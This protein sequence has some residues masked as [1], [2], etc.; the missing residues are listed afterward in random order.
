MVT[1]A[2]LSNPQRA[3]LVDVRESGEVGFE[4]A[5]NQRR[6]MTSLVNKGLVSLDQMG[7]YRMTEQG[8]TLFPQPEPEPPTIEEAQEDGAAQSETVAAAETTPAPRRRQPR[9]EDNRKVLPLRLTPEETTALDIAYREAGYR[10]RTKFLR[11][12]IAQLLHEHDLLPEEFSG[13]L[14]L[15]NETLAA[16]AATEEAA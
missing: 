9:G 11:A 16:A 14:E 8:E 12:A 5:P 3:C 15:A 4:A 1:M 6:T 13:D 10:T 7:M 2:S